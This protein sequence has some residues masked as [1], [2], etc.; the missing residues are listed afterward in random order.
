LIKHNAFKVVCFIIAH[1]KDG[2]NSEER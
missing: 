2:A 1:L